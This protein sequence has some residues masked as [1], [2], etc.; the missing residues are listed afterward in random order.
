MKEPIPANPPGSE[1]QLLSTLG[2]CCPRPQKTPARETRARRRPRPCTA[3]PQHAPF[4]IEEIPF[5][6]NSPV[7]GVLK[8][9]LR[10]VINP[11]F[12]QC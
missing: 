2:G 9:S 4:R 7:H 12:L 1:G 5:F 6:T 3:S 8:N 11:R 10:Y